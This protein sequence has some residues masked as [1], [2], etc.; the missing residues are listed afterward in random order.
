MKI[1]DFFDSIYI[2]N[3]IERK[4]RRDQIVKELEKINIYLTPGKVELFSAVKPTEA[5]GFETSGTRGCFLSHLEILKIAQ[6]KG[7]SNILVIEDDLMISEKFLD[8]QDRLMN[9]LQCSDWGFVYFGHIENLSGDTF[10]QLQSYPAAKGIQTSHFYGINSTVFN[11]LIS[12]MDSLQERAPADP[13]GGPMHL[14]GA[15]SFFRANNPKILT[16]IS[17]PNLGSQRSSRS[18]VHELKWFD[19]VKIFRPILAFLRNIKTSL[20]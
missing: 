6:E 18:D 7:L 13:L 12:F 16:L 3:L 17:C 8:V 9:Q 2:V 5:K 19:K 10:C 1:Q 14:D 4:D 20:F 11:P 15:Y